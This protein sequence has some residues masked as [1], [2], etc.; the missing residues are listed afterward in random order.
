M[1]KKPGGTTV[2]FFRSRSELAYAKAE[3]RGFR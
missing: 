1:F 2:S 3:Q